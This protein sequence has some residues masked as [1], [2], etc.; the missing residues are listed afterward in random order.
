MRKSALIFSAVL[1]LLLASGV[2]WAATV[3]CADA[4]TVFCRGTD[5]PDTIYGTDGQDAISARDGADK[6]YGRGGN[7]EELE[8]GGVSTAEAAPMWSAAGKAATTFSAVTALTGC[9]A[10]SATTT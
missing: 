5:G 3:D 10:T 8:V 9:S 2:A 4:S 7:D 6:V 1:V